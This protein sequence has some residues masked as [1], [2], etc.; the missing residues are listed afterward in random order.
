MAGPPLRGRPP[1]G[2]ASI[3]LKLIR[4]T[5][6]GDVDINIEMQSLFERLIIGP[7]EHPETLRRFFRKSFTGAG[8]SPE[9][10][11]IVTSDIPLRG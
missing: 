8:I 3:P 9:Q 5:D 6:E 10:I 2:I 4:A 1:Q 7:T 11:E